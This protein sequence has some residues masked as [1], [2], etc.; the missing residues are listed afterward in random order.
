LDLI[1]VGIVTLKIALGYCLV[2]NVEIVESRI[3]SGIELDA[4]GTKK[5]TTN[6]A[7]REFQLADAISLLGRQINHLNRAFTFF[8][9]SVDKDDPFA[10]PVCGKREDA[11]VVTRIETENGLPYSK[12]QNSVFLHPSH[13]ISVLNDSKIRFS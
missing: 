3:L 2:G 1:G 8:P 9:V 13:L 6:I 7:G 12:K 4:C 10:Y 5:A 11:L